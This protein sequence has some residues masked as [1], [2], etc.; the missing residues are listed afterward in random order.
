MALDLNVD[1]ITLG[2]YRKYGRFDA[3]QMFRTYHSWDT[4]LKKSGLSSTKF[5]IGQG[6]QI[7]DRELLVDILRVWDELG[8]QP[9]TTDF[10]DGKFKFSLNTYTRRFGSWENALSAFEI[11]VDDDDNSA[12]ELLICSKTDKI[13]YLNRG[14]RNIPL[15]LRLKVMDRD[16]YMCVKCHATRQTN[17][18]LEF[19]IDHI[20]PWSEGG[21]TEL[22]NLQLLCS[23]CNLKK[24]NKIE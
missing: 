19:H 9:K 23:K 15:S 24:S 5:R 6:K 18:T 10:H 13:P 11:W 14:S 4:I 16:G 20:I 7:T 3:S 12:E 8:R 22:N 17:P 2:D 21:K 1:S